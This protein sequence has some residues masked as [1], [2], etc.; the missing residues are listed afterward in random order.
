MT[1]LLDGTVPAGVRGVLRPGGKLSCLIHEYEVGSTRLQPDICEWVM[2]TTGDI[3]EMIQM[4]IWV[5]Y[6]RCSRW[7]QSSRWRV[8]DS[9]I[10]LALVVRH[11]STSGD[12]AAA[13]AST[14]ILPRTAGMMI[15]VGC[16]TLPSLISPHSK[17]L[18]IART[19]KPCETLY[20]GL[21]SCLEMDLSTREYCYPARH[22]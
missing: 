22:H 17:R 4:P 19:M 18:Q 3:L 14:L 11:R 20:S 13:K 1:V 8:S 21:S 16:S 7:Q 9:L 10:S 12:L 6:S 15:L 5:V 2:G